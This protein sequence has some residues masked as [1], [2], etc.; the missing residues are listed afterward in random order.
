MVL[1]RL[2]LLLLLLVV[3]VVLSFSL[4]PTSC[5]Y[6]SF[7]LRGTDDTRMFCLVSRLT[8]VSCM[9]TLSDTDRISFVLFCVQSQLHAGTSVSGQ[10]VL[11]G[12]FCLSLTSA[13]RSFTLVLARLLCLVSFV[14]FSFT[15]FHAT[16]VLTRLCYFV[17]SL[18][19]TSASRS[20]TLSG[21]KGTSF[22]FSLTLVSR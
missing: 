11:T 5:S 2:G 22:F 3:V 13:S 17:P 10:V 14:D 21:T 12:V 20:F 19:L 6:V 8:L 9:F 1:T 4:K 15:Q 7:T 16:G 18:P